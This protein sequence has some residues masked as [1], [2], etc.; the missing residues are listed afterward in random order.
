VTGSGAALD[1]THE[2]LDAVPVNGRW[3]VKCRC[4][5]NSIGMTLDSAARNHRAHASAALL[6]GAP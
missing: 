5:Q 4:G 3:V 6:L 2:A 1:H